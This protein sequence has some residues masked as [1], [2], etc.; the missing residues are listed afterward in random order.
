MPFRPPAKAG[1]LKKVGDGKLGM[2]ETFA[3]PG[4]PMMYE[5]SY[6]DKQGKRHGV[7]VKADGSETKE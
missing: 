2:V 3:K 4:Q 5:A 7:L 1:I 6:T